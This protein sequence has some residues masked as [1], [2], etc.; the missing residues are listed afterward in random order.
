MSKAAVDRSILEF[1]LWSDYKCVVHLA[2]IRWGDSRKVTCPHCSSSS[3]HYWQKTRLRWK[4]KGCGSTFSVTSQTVFANRR[5]SLQSILAAVHAWAAGAAGHAALQTRRLIKTGGY[6]T[7]FT[8]QAKLREGLLRLGNTGLISGVVE[9]DAAHAGGR[10]ASEKRNRPQTFRV[11]SPEAAMNDALLTSSA[12]SK[13]KRDE[14]KKTLAEGGRVGEYGAAHPDARRFVFTARQ[15]SGVKGKGASITRIGVGLAESPEVAES[16][17]E[18][19]IAIPESILSTDSGNAFK[20]LGKQFRLHLEVNHS[21]TL[22]GP[23]GQHNNNAESFTARNDRAEKGV[24]LNIEEKYTHDY[25]V[26]MAFRED[27]RRMATGA[28]SDRALHFALNV[29]LSQFW[30]GFTHGKHRGYE[31]LYPTDMPARASGPCKGRS[32]I[33]SINGRPPR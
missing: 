14:K 3:E 33:S 22:V 23:D 9:M 11:S 7:T 4:C 17:A 26:E 1:P 24:H 10:R 8:L 13:Q 5:L 18:A 21:E 19:Y 15:R 20:R 16:I 12:R 31:I 27:H 30:R 28:Q 32:P 2:K 6:N 29:G 25:A